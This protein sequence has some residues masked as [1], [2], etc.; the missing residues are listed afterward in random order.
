MTTDLKQTPNALLRG[1]P[2]T[3]AEWTGGLYRERFQTVADVTVPH[4]QHMWEEAGISHVLENFRIAAGETEGDF[5]G[6][7]FGDGDFYKWMEA[8]VYTAVRRGDQNLLDRLEEWVGLIGRAQQPDGYLSTKQIIGERTG[9]AV[10]MGNIN[11]FEVYNF[12]HLFTA[13]CLY[14][15]LTG[16]DSLLKIAEKTA[17]YL[18]GLYRTAKETGEARTAVCPSHYMG[19][20]EL[21]RTTGNKRYLQ[22]LETALELRDTV[23]NGLDDNQDRHPLR[24]HRTIHGHAVRANYLYAGV[25]DYCLETDEPELEWVLERVWNSLVRQKIYITG[26]CGALYNGASPYGNFW[27]HQ[28]VHQAYGY[29]YQLPNVTAYNETC[30]AVGGIMWAWRLLCL[31]KDPAVADVLERMMLNVCMAGVS[32]NGKEFFYENMLRRAESLPYELC[33]GQERSEYIRSYC[34][35]PN[36]TRLLA[37]SSEYAYARDDEAL[38]VILYGQSHAILEQENGAVEVLQE[39]D[40]PYDG[41]IRFT[42][43]QAAGHVPEFRLTLRIPGWVRG[44]RVVVKRGSEVL[45]EY[46]GLCGS[47]W[48]VLDL[49]RPDECEVLVNWNMRPRLT[50]AHSLVEEAAGQVAVEYGP[51]VYCA[52]GM[53]APLETLDD[54]V[55]P[56]DILLQP[57]PFT[58]GGREVISLTG[59]FY[60]RKALCDRTALYQEYRA[61]GYEPVQVRMIPYFAWANRG[62]DEMR[63]WIPVT[64]YPSRQ[65]EAE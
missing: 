36:V 54:L 10:R 32:L 25:A 44:G 37:E 56:A 61:G 42:F 58:I 11:D 16:R 23:R 20:A 40:Y 65:K 26:G 28:L 41:R 6:T 64:E 27:K 3:D 2:Y 38:Y 12:G 18:D 53:D 34:C 50:M 7:P 21:Y 8:A 57:E 17:D 9:R 60:R 24:E 46:P 63:V 35:P 49:V 14:Y 52:E 59:S 48:L 13:A 39:T 43:R 29:E 15:R 62:H 33:W 1:L 51:L 45:H 47:G 30:A 5:R 19:L 22:M 4:L 55:I 31:W